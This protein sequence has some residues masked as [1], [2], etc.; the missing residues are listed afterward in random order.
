MNEFDVFINQN[1]DTKPA[2]FIGSRQKKIAG[3]FEIDIFKIITIG[4]ILRNGQIFNSCF[5]NEI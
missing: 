4:D 3:L 5:V 1:V 2:H